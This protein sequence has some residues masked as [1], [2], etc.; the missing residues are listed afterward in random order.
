MP[1][2]KKETNAMTQDASESIYRLIALQFEET[3]LNA[4]ELLAVFENLYGV[5]GTEA[6]RGHPRFKALL[7]TL[8]M[9]LFSLENTEGPHLEQLARTMVEVHDHAG[10]SPMMFVMHGDRIE[11]LIREEGGHSPLLK[12]FRLLKYAVAKLHDE[13]IKAEAS[14]KQAAL[15]EALDALMKTMPVGFFTC[16]IETGAI[17]DANPAF[18]TMLGYG[19]E[20]LLGKTWYEIIPP[21]VVQ[22]ELEENEALL[23]GDISMIRREK[24]FITKDGTELPVVLY[25]GKLFDPRVGK[26]VYIDFAADVS[27]LKKAQKR[28]DEAYHYFYEV[29]DQTNEMLVVFDSKGGILEVNQALEALKKVFRAEDVI[30]RLGGDEFAALLVGANGETFKGVLVRIGEA[31]ARENETRPEPRLSLSAG[32]AFAPQAP[33]QHEALFQ[34]ADR[35]MYQDKIARKRAGGKG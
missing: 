4:P 11:D 26:E 32:F 31:I 35:A 25:F 13:F 18:L 10:V 20:E 2:Q 9:L 6:V 17:Y 5:S 16:D 15:L 21:Q 29:F 27:E 30:A 14:R 3:N 24:T 12:N 28:L 7:G 33:F 19:R 1:H 22:Q 34:A 23:K 8:E